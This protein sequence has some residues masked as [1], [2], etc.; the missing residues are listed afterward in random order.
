MQQFP[1]ATTNGESSQP[2]NVIPFL[3]ID[4]LNSHPWVAGLKTRVRTTGKY[5]ASGYALRNDLDQVIPKEPTESDTLPSGVFLYEHKPDDP[6]SLTDRA[7][8]A[9]RD[10]KRRWQVTND[11]RI[12]D[13]SNLFSLALNT[14]SANS[15]LFIKTD[16]TWQEIESQVP[17]NRAIP[18]IRLAQLLHASKSVTIMLRR[19][20]QLFS[21][22]HGN[23]L[24]ST[25]DDIQTQLNQFTADHSTDGKTVSIDTLHCVAIFQVLQGDQYQAF[26]DFC[27]NDDSL[28]TEPVKLTNTLL[29]FMAARRAITADPP[30]V[31][32]SYL[33]TPN[34]PNSPSSQ[35]ATYCIK[36]F[37]R[38]KGRKF[39]NHGI[40]G[41]PACK[42]G[43]YTSTGLR[44]PRPTSRSASEKT[45]VAA[46]RAYLA[47]YQADPSS[48]ESI[49]ALVSI[50]NLCS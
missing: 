32:G 25:L 20:V 41:T 48:E 3:S 23:T 12:I 9:F 44:Q 18:F 5:G 27:L 2:E 38:T 7:Y 43:A 36:C 29:R 15:L 19:A 31:Q 35:P 39:T 34:T 50:A 37:N 47:H 42:D 16:P 40:P 33:T 17:G 14:T 10:D 26:L 30:S 28:L 46:N 4:L 45:L 49:N 22:V 13:D 8:T 24:L 21:T 6:S 1:Q 11:T